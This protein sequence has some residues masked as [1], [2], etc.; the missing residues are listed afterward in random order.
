MALEAHEY[1]SQNDWHASGNRGKHGKWLFERGSAQALRLQRIRRA[2]QLH[3]RKKQA[4]QA[5]TCIGKSDVFSTLTLESKRTYSSALAVRFP[6]ETAA[7]NQLA[8][9]SIPPTGAT[10]PS[11]EKSTPVSGELERKYN[12]PQK[13]KTPNASECI[14]IR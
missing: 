4:T 12:E 8:T 9:K 10:G 11:H 7:S 14:A 13:H 1:G 6:K 3:A 5:T 2:Q